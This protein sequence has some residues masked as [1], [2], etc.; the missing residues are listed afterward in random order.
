[1]HLLTVN[2]GSSSVRLSIYAD[3][4]HC[5]ASAHHSGSEPKQIGN[6][7]EARTLDVVLSDNSDACRSVRNPLGLLRYTRN[8]HVHQIFQTHIR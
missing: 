4:G 1:M 8:L 6:A 3:D 2:V 7:V 5:L